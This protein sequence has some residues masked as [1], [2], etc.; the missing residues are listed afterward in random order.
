LDIY[1]ERD[2]YRITVKREKGIHGLKVYGT[3][4]ADILNGKDNT[5]RILRDILTFFK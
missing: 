3:G 1:Y 4:R 2:N 5:I